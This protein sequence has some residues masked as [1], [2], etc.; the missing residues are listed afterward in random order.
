MNRIVAR[1]QAIKFSLKSHKRFWKLLFMR[2]SWQLKGR[3]F[4]WSGHVSLHNSLCKTIVRGTLE[5]GRRTWL[6]EEMLDGQHQK[7]DIPANASTAHKGS[8][9]KGWKR[10]SAESSLMSLRWPNR[11]RAWRELNCS[12]VQSVQTRKYGKSVLQSVGSRLEAV[13][14]HT[15]RMMA[16][17]VPRSKQS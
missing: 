1:T 10:I 3:K 11:S 5:V 9:R 13:S 12:R 14:S 15:L 17:S 7:V 8:C 2:P 4:V 16:G 6:A